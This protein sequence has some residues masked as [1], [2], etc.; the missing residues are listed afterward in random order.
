MS[1]D[2]LA[3]VAKTSADIS[4]LGSSSSTQCA[5]CTKKVLLKHQLRPY[6]DLLVHLHVSF[7]CTNT[8]LL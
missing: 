3:L 5:V 1:Q 7:L 6:V 2:C 8:S 4:L